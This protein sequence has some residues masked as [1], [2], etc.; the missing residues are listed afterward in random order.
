MTIFLITSLTIISSIFVIST[1][2]PI[3]SIIALISVVL[4]LVVLSILLE[5][6]FLALSFV[7]V[8]LGAVTV[9]FLFI[10]MMLNIK[11]IDFRKSMVRALP[12]GF[13]FGFILVYF[14]YTISAKH[15]QFD[16]EIA[17]FFTPDMYF[18][19]QSIMI[20]TPNINVLGAVLY[21][22]FSPY[23]LMVGIILLVAMIGVMVLAKTSY[24]ALDKKRNFIDQQVSRSFDKAVFFVNDKKKSS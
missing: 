15:V 24:L 8:Y 6:E 5:A 19:W 7:A 18:D 20:D 2:S 10:V 22:H 11:G 12:V 23:L 13:L 3:H 14:L 1:R 17:V 4:N 21:T 9:L 16:E